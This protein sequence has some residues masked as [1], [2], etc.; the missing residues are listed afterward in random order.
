[1]RLGDAKVRGMYDELRGLAKDAAKPF[2]MP[3]DHK[4]YYA[5]SLALAVVLMTL[6]PRGLA[7]DTAFYQGIGVVMALMVVGLYVWR[8]RVPSWR[9]RR[10]DLGHNIVRKG[11]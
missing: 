9:I 5:I 11:L 7:A 4:R 1:L 10:K 6:A 2:W 3:S 8:H